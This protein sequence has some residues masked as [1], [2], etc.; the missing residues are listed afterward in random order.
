MLSTV[1]PH[2][3]V[4]IVKGFGH[5]LHDV[6][7][8]AI[9]DM[10]AS[11]PSPNAA[12]VLLEV[13]YILTVSLESISSEV[14]FKSSSVSFVSTVNARAASLWFQSLAYSTRMPS[15]VSVFFKLKIRPLRNVQVK[16]VKIMLLGRP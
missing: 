1:Y 9:D 12:N 14:E 3:A 10:F 16:A 5:S 6:L 8:M 11:S 7:V 4:M 15:V 2:N 13:L